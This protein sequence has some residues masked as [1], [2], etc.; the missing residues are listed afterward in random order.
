MDTYLVAAAHFPIPN[1]AAAASAVAQACGGPVVD[2]TVQLRRCR[3]IVADNLPREQAEAMAGALVQAG[4]QAWS[5]PAADIPALPPALTAHC[6]DPRDPQNLLAA[7]H[8][9]VPPELLPW[10]HIAAVL[11]AKWHVTR[12]TEERAPMRMSY[13][14]AVLDQALTGGWQMQRMMAGNTEKTG[15]SSE[16]VYAEAMVEIVALQ[17]LRRIHAF[18]GHIDYSPLAQHGVQGADNWK[19]LLQAL[20]DRT[21][22]ATVGRALLEAAIRGEDAPAMLHVSDQGDLGRTVRWLM[23]LATL[24]RVTGRH[25]GA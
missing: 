13:G 17:P 24:E 8:F 21:R 19:H 11:P 7:V 2:R 20:H 15:H 6:L 25:A 23:I 22:A 10:T 18:A 4:C 3:G 1:L 14:G 12:H 9:T 5:L 16:K